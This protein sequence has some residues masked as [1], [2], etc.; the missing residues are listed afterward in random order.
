MHANKGEYR[1]A[2]ALL[3][4]N[5]SVEAN[6]RSGDYLRLARD[7]LAPTGR[8]DEAIANLHTA[9]AR[10]PTFC[11]A[12]DAAG[13]ILFKHGRDVEAFTEWEKGIAAVP[14]CD[15]NYVHM[16]HALVERKRV[17]DAKQ[18]LVVLLKKSPESDGAVIAKELLATL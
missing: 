15:L 14:K 5:L 8:V 7:V 9:Y 12:Y 18:K 16:A 2:E 17:G 3:R 4:Q 6:A 11:T 1:E 13:T 10:V